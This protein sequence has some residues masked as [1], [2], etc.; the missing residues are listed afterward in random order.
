[1]LWSLS[2]QQAVKWWQKSQ[3]IHTWLTDSRIFLWDNKDNSAQGKTV[4]RKKEGW[5][6]RQ[7]KNLNA[8]LTKYS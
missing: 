4:K 8:E 2:S 6:E 3:L 5:N 7:E 1:M